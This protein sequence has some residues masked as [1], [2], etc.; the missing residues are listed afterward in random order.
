[1]N[2]EI[3][4]SIFAKHM[5]NELFDSNLLYEYWSLLIDQFPIKHIRNLHIQRVR[6]ML[7]TIPANTLDALV[8]LYDYKHIN[9]NRLDKTE[10][11]IELL[12]YYAKHRKIDSREYHYLSTTDDPNDYVPFNDWIHIIQ[13]HGFVCNTTQPPKPKREKKPKEVPNTETSSVPKPKRDKK[14]K[15]ENAVEPKPKREK[16]PKEVTEIPPKPKREKKE[17]PNTETSSVP[18]PKREKK[19]KEANAGEANPKR[20][21]KSKSK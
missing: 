4:S 9:E 1:M 16:K 21:T 6:N 17:V 7:N 19:T 3:D 8:N 11:F 14:P 2:I 13:K 10:F 5:S 20:A 18:K 15:E 12:F